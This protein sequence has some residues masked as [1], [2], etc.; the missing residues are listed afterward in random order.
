MIE[1]AERPIDGLCICSGAM[2]A[3]VAVVEFAVVTGTAVDGGVVPLGLSSGCP[4]R[5]GSG[6][7]A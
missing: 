4:C 7:W 3:V 2:F 1:V 5:G 6:C